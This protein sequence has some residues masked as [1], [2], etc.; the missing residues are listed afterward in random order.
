MPKTKLEWALWYAEKEMLVFP[1][2]I[3]NKEP[4]VRRFQV[5][6]T[7]DP[8]QI[9]KWWTK[10]PNANIGVLTDYNYDGKYL[11]VVDV[12][13]K[14]GASGSDTLEALADVDKVLPPTFTIQT[15]SW[16]FH[17][18]FFSDGPIK[19]AAG[20]LGIGLDTRSEGGYVAGA[21]STYSVDGKLVEYK[22]FIDNEI[23]E[24]P[25]WVAEMAPKT[26][27]AKEVSG[28]S[29]KVEGIN[30]EI[31]KARAIKYLNNLPETP[32]GERNDTGFE[33]ACKIKDFGLH[34]AAN[35]EVMKTHWKTKTPMEHDEIIKFVNSAYK[36]GQNEPGCDPSA[37]D[38]FEVIEKSPETPI[39][40]KTEAP[41]TENNIPQKKKYFPYGVAGEMPIETDDNYLIMN[42]LDRGDLSMLYGAPGGG[43]TTVAMSLAHHIAMGIDWNG[44][45]VK[46]GGAIILTL[47]GKYSAIMRIQAQIKYMNLE[48]KFIPFFMITGPFSALSKP[49]VEKLINT[50][51]EIENKYQIKIEVLIVDTLSRSTAGNDENNAKDV[52]MVVKTFDFIREL[53]KVAIILI[54]HSGKD[55]SKGGRGSNALLGAVGTEFMADKIDNQH[56][57]FFTKQRNY[58]C[59]PPIA[60]NLKPIE[61]GHSKSGKVI[62]SV[63]AEFTNIVDA[64]EFD[65]KPLVGNA[66]DVYNTLAK[67]LHAKGKSGLRPSITREDWRVTYRTTYCAAKTEDSARRAFER[68]LSKLVSESYVEEKNEHYWI[69]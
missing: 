35:A 3:N 10:F 26:S 64:K 7:T 61:L 37:E 46:Q 24:M 36:N 5:L 13:N 38:E 9:K 18:Y 44:R 66:A 25:W 68:G 59:A 52:S 31:A 16:G 43:K 32:A 60:F 51:F 6:A 34:I 12:D 45:K 39:E 65:K 49:D 17:Y 11:N 30:Q 20:T 22:I 47:E 19:S 2:I 67:L 50:I 63:V 21:G 58:E 53:A 15:P 1:L 4:L 69:N 40:K 57:I 27:K 14:N 55:K 62:T 42:T 28:A 41:V 54:H 56:Q 8:K 23:A 29:G 48:N 33:Y